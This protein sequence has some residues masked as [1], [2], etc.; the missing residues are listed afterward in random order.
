M[1]T[2]NTVIDDIVA[3]DDYFIERIISGLPVGVSVVE[4]WLT[5]KANLTDLDSA[6]LIQKNIT[7]VDV[8]GQG[9]IIDD[10]S[11]GTAT[12]RFDLVPADTA[13]IPAAGRGSTGYPFDI[14]VRTSTG[15]IYT[16][17]IGTIS[18]IAQVT[19]RTD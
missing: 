17:E 18:S 4:A 2:F 15:R 7:G 16:P 13:I 10:G 19:L 3:G 12:I 11:D 5:V 14:Q 6:A 1:P 8:V 9:V